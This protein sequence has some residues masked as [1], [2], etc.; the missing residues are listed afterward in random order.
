MKR[1]TFNHIGV[2]P[3][4]VIA[5]AAL[6]L[7]V[8]WAGAA[9]SPLI[10]YS[11]EEGGGTTIS[12]RAPGVVTNGVLH[13]AA[14]AWTSGAPAGASPTG[15]LVF[16]GMNWNTGGVYIVTLYGADELG[17]QDTGYTTTAWIRFTKASGDA[18]VFG[19]ITLGSDWLHDGVRGSK[20]HLGH[21]GSDT[22]GLSTLQ[23]GVWYHV[24]WQF[25]QGTQRIF[26]NG[27]LDNFQRGRVAV[28]FADAVV[29]GDASA[30]GGRATRDRMA[31]VGRGT[32]IW[33]L[34]ERA[35]CR[36]PGTT[37]T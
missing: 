17:L 32:S 1:G 26:V 9:P 11:F 16:D 5:V 37:G 24:A 29:I 20:A 8:G 22:T 23:T 31:L 6:V 30:A 7:T 12:N 4:A 15:G 33:S 25:E 27:R 35:V 2:R 34:A 10:Y 3:Q 28:R 14:A 13:G 18:M 36:R 21:F 19:Q